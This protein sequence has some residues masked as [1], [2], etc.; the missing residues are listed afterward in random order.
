MRKQRNKFDFSLR[1][2]FNIILNNL[3]AVLSTLTCW[4]RGMI[5]ASGARGSGFK[6]RMSPMHFVESNDYSCFLPQCH[7]T[8]NLS[9][10]G[11][12]IMFFSRRKVSTFLR[13]MIL[14]SG[15][16]GPGFK[17]L[18][19]PIHFVESN[20]YSC[21]LPLRHQMTN[22]SSLGMWMMFFLRIK[23]SSSARGMIL[24]YGRRGPG[25]MSPEDP[26]VFCR[27]KCLIFLST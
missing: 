21:F 22:L 11:M 24:A 8:T 14:A 3:S 27:M 18:T 19:S 9:S 6:C 5:L 25:F 1:S 10:L 26:K 7:R 17:S 13:G 12:W 15:A 16:R 23:I 4:S 20:D 2:N